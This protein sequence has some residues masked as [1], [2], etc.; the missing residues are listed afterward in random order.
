M[1][2]SLGHGVLAGFLGAAF[3]ALNTPANAQVSDNFQSYAPGS[4]PAPT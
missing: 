1:K 3:L 2:R 4:L